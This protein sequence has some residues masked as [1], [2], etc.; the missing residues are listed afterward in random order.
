MVN[1]HCIELFDSCLPLRQDFDSQKSCGETIIYEFY[2]DLLEY[3]AKACFMIRSCGQTTFT[4]ICLKDHATFL[5]LIQHQYF[6][7]RNW[8][9]ITVYS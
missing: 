5:E 7:R 6:M 4:V 8:L 2:G 3:R 9:V 1:N